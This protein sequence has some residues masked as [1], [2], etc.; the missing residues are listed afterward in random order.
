MPFDGAE[1]LRPRPAPPQLRG[2]WRARCAAVLRTILLLPRPT[3]MPEPLLQILEEARGLIEQRDDW[4]RGAYQTSAGERCAVGALR[5]A[6]A[7]LNYPAAGA[8]AEVLVEAIVRQ[9]GFDAIEAMN[10]RAGHDKILSVFDAAIATVA[11]RN[12]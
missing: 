4:V 12:R 10:D 7:L 5:A 8:T 3:T 11:T 6:A 9:H 2:G 1:F